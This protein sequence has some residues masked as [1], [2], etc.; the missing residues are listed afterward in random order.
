MIYAVNIG[1]AAP[2]ALN[3][4]AKADAQRIRARLRALATDPRPPGAERMQGGGGALR[5]RIGDFRVIYE[6]NDG[7]L[8]VLVI[9]IGHRR[10][11]DR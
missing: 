2:K 3:G 1:N 9:T 4:N 7:Q 5:I 8:V 10:E 11:V 6:I